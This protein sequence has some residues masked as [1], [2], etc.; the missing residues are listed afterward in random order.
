MS[1]P[2]K[3]DPDNP[4]RVESIVAEIQHE[5]KRRRD[6]GEYPPEVA[7]E[8]DSGAEDTWANREVLIRA[9]GQ[10]RQA[11]SFST[12]VPTDSAR[13]YLG[14]AISSAKKAVHRSIRWYVA[15]VLDQVRVFSEMSLRT[16]KLLA[17]RSLQ[18]ESRLE[19]LESEMAQ[20]RSDRS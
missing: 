7:A 13:P 2:I 12:I 8:I 16:T 15:G 18:L 14:T 11:T 19:R 17:D 6:A 3:Q 1:K 4:I 5:V 20:M 10:L 9:L